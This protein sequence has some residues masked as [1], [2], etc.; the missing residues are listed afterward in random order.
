[1]GN[2]RNFDYGSFEVKTRLIHAIFPQYDSQETQPNRLKTGPFT[3]AT[4]NT[5]LGAQGIYRDNGKEHG[6]CHVG[7]GV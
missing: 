1:M 6:N 4:V 2:T 7:F 3:C 5:T